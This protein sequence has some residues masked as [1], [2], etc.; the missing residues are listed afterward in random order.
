MHIREHF[1]AHCDAFTARLTRRVD[2]RRH[3]RNIFCNYRR[4]APRGETYI[5]T[6][7]RGWL[8]SLCQ[9][10]ID[11]AVEEPRARVVSYEPER[12]IIG[13]A[14]SAYDVAHNGIVE[15][16]RRVAC[17]TDDVEGMSMQV[18]RVLLKTQEL[19]DQQS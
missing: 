6:R 17:A 15:V 16:V 4:E 18:D 1:L 13:R 7:K 19:C 10:P 5:D 8:D 14:A 11:M 12:N 2:R 3:I 9:V